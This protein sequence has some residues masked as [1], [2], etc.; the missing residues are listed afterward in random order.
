MSTSAQHHKTI[1]IAD[2]S[3]IIRM[4]MGGILSDK[5]DIVEV[6][7][8]TDALEAMRELGS[9][10]IACVLLDLHMPG[11]ADYE[12][13][14]RKQA[15]PSIAD[16]PVIIV[17][18]DSVTE[19]EIAALDLGAS[20]FLVKPIEPEIMRRR[21]RSVVYAREAEDQRLR[22]RMLE[23]RAWHSDHDD[24]TG[25]FTR[26]A[27]IRETHA[28]LD[29]DPDTEF[30][31]V[32]WD[33]ERFKMLNELFGSRLGDE[34]LENAAHALSEAIEGRGRYCR[35]GDDFF[36][37]CVPAGA[38]DVEQVI[39]QISRSVNALLASRGIGFALAIAAGVYPVE[40]HDADVSIMLDRAMSARASAKG[41]YGEHIAVY[42]SELSGR[43][44]EEQ[45][46]LNNM[47]SALANGEFQ[48]VLQPVYDLA[49][50]SPA[51][52][53]ALVR[54]HRPGHG[55]VS[56]GMFIPLFEENG[57][58][59]KLD[60]NVWEQVCQ[61]LAWRREQG[62][63][64]IPI[65]VNLSRRSIYH[66]RL[67]ES[68]VELTKKYDVKPELFRIE[69]TESSYVEDSERLIDTVRQL[70]DHGFT[71]L[72][73][74]F[75]SGYSSLI[76]LKDLPV[77][78]LKADMMLLRDLETSDRV[79]SIFTAIVRMA[80]WL[81]IPVIAEG[82]ET[83]EQVEFL[84]SVG[85]DYTQGYYF[86]RPMPPEEFEAHLKEHPPK[87]SPRARIDL[88]ADDIDA[89]MGGNRLFEQL[90]GTMFDAYLVL[91]WR[92]GALET[93]RASNGIFDLLALERGGFSF[94]PD[95]LRRLFAEEEVVRFGEACQ[96]AAVEQT[97]AELE[98]VCVQADGARVP[99]LVFILR[100]GA[101]K[102]YAMLL[103]GMK[104][105]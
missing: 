105:K 12:V 51:S 8:G 54:W 1:L 30:I 18:A 59:T 32:V 91:E 28:M 103:V 53:E 7:N 80:R 57:F 66:P 68:I 86:A 17:T 13:L 49:T 44:R 102:G 43:L 36:A 58:I 55:V 45:D 9:D 5:Y 71:I 92:D 61:H 104:R 48:I 99:V 15:D 40:D 22:I 27:F 38:V 76:S 65:S 95:G 34:V 100:I 26:K 14:V 16:I 41:G 23:E 75:G 101:S 39:E 10:R 60:Q 98:T 2:N 46:I 93:V 21:V 50:S 35:L 37:F 94:D 29:A 73:D 88:S 90:M 81:G 96:R 97:R 47:E 78:I 62:L 85:C 67:V 79:G 87:A 33:F 89:V 19:A 83:A 63:P 6:D 74:D 77:D 31:V 84:R 82:A 72:M 69:V 70:Q 11:N 24:L 20:D 4:Q 3:P 64:E 52:A 25:I 56:P 42:D